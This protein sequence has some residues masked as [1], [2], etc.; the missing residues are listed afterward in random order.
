[1]SDWGANLCTAVLALVTHEWAFAAVGKLVSAQGAILSTAVHA[2]VT[3]VR[4]FAAGKVL[5][6]IFF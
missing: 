2:L 1:M 4:A 6:P 3:L 5:I